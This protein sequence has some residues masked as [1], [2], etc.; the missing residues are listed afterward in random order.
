MASPLPGCMV[1][2]F[3]SY[4]LPRN[5]ILLAHKVK[6]S[7]G[8]AVGGVYLPLSPWDRSKARLASSGEHLK[9][10]ESLISG[11]QYTLSSFLPLRAR[12]L[13]ESLSILRQK[14][15]DSGNKGGINIH[16]KRQH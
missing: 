10:A 15:R 11:P 5:L 13:F 2:D 6:A 3:R 12:R 1:S 4:S 8:V 16:Q 14:E 9:W 7:P